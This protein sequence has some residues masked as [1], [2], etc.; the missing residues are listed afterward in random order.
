MSKKN[1]LEENEPDLWALQAARAQDQL[2][3]AIAANV[4][5]NG[6]LFCGLNAAIVAFA[7]HP[8]LALLAIVP[9]GASCIVDQLP[10]ATARKFASL[11]TYAFAAAVL[12]LSI[13]AA[14]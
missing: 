7:G 13:F 12:A 6:R 14:I 10:N 3:L 1:S 8:I 11:A 2:G 9:I 5:T 4:A